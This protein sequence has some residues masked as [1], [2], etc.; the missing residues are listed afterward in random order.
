MEEKPLRILITGSRDWPTKDSVKSDLIKFQG[1]DVIIIHGACP[2]KKR[3]RIVSNVP[4]YY[5]A[6]Y[7]A[8]EVAEELG[9]K[10]EKY[11][12]DWDKYGKRAAFIRNKEMVDSSPDSVLAYHKNNSSGTAMTIKLAREAGIKV[13]GRFILDE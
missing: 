8:N 11:P 2:P 5:G 10:V 7:F 6:D 13:Y 3:L 9:F 12:A 4:E 1:R